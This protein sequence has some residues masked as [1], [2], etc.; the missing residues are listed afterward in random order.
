MSFLT[1][2]SQDQSDNKIR[3]NLVQPAAWMQY[4]QIKAEVGVI[5]ASKMV[6]HPYGNVNAT[7]EFLIQLKVLNYGLLKIW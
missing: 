7:I 3:L 5:L 2:C 6:I 1:A 4:H